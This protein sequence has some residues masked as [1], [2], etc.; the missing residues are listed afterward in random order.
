MSK[1]NNK[2]GRGNPIAGT[3]PP[4]SRRAN[5]RRK[6]TPGPVRGG[7]YQDKGQGIISSYQQVPYASGAAL[8]N[9]TYH[10]Q[11][12]NV[13]HAALGLN[14]VK[15]VGCQPYLAVHLVNLTEDFFVTDGAELYDAN[16]QLINPILLGGPLAARAVT[17][18]R[19]VFRKIRLIYTTSV[20]AATVGQMAVCITRDPNPDTDIPTT[21]SEIRMTQPSLAAPRWY[22][23]WVLEYDYD[24]NELY[25]VSKSASST[26]AANIRQTC[27]CATVG[28][29]NVASTSSS[30]IGYLMIEYEIDFFNPTFVQANLYGFRSLDK[31]IDLKYKKLYD[32]LRLEFDQEV[33]EAK[34]SRSHDRERKRRENKVIS[35]EIVEGELEICEEIPTGNFPVTKL[36]APKT[37]KINKIVGN[38]S[39]LQSTR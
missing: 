1:H 10:R 29:H 25:F 39:L 5:Q 17:F 3:K 38:S 27:Q 35:D 23:Y 18:D 28:Y 20:S 7:V 24:G 26:V 19:Y 8:R 22:P 13:R 34:V 2:P 14:G 30:N 15:I 33:E 32:Q 16:T 4:R 12:G 9:S 37:L 21:F 31:S 36:V 11:S 6:L